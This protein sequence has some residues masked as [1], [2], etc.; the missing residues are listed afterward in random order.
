VGEPISDR[1]FAVAVKTRTLTLLARLTAE[2]V[3]VNGDRSWVEAA[4]ARADPPFSP[5]EAHLVEAADEY[6]WLMAEILL[7]LYNGDTAGMSVVDFIA[8]GTVLALWHA[9]PADRRRYLRMVFGTEMGPPGASKRDR[10]ALL[11]RLVDGAG[12][13]VPAALDLLAIITSPSPVVEEAL[14]ELA[15]ANVPASVAGDA[16]GVAR[17]FTQ[18][19]LAGEDPDALIDEFWPEREVPP[20]GDD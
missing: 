11:D 18:R 15:T 19:L 10:L 13:E 14:E 5:Y 4:V 7:R 8:P 1:A 12:E 3:P 16:A 2:E 17:D 6:D 9:L 20:Y